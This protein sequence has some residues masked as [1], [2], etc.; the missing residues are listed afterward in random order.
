MT[1]GPLAFR[2]ALVL[3]AL[4]TSGCAMQSTVVDL[5]QQVAALKYRSDKGRVGASMGRV[6]PGTAAAAGVSA[7]EVL[8]LTIAVDQLHTELAEVRGQLD[9]ITFAVTTLTQGTDARLALLE[10]KAGVTTL[11]SLGGGR[12]SSEAASGTQELAP[13]IT[14]PDAGTAATS[15]PAPQVVLPGVMIAPANKDASGAISAKTA[16]GLAGADFKRGHYNLAAAGFANFLEQYPESNLTPAAT[17]WLGESY[18]GQGLLARATKVWEQQTQTFP[19]H[20]ESRRALLRLGEVYRS[21]DNIPAAE[22]A[23]KKLIASFQDSAEA[24]QAKLILSE[25][26]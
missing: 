20:D 4:V 18:R 1:H 22:K 19:R 14:V 15:V 16:Y 23:L 13:P 7:T 11:P 5:E 17:Y 24:Q 12:E 10:E 6:D 3:L 26:R 2:A 9:E 21:M 25:I 8:D